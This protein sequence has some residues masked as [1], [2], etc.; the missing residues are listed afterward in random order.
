MI[1]LLNPI[2]SD[3]NAMRQTLLFSGLETIVRNVN[4]RNQN[5]QLFEFGKTYSLN[6]N[7]K[8]EDVTVRFVEK[9][10]LALF[11]TGKRIEESWNQSGVDV[12]FFYLKNTFHNY[13]NQI[14][15]Y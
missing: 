10:T 3:L 9:E 2:S 15:N 12:D 4:N 1:H 14:Q 5:L 11:L 7:T 8:E 6:T 13:Y